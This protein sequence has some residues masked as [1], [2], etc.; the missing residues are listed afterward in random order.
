[1][2]TIQQEI[3]DCKGN[4]E[5]L[6]KLIASKYDSEITRENLKSDCPDLW[7]ELLR[8]NQ[9]DYDLS[10]INIEIHYNCILQCLNK[11]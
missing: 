5:A 10:Y 1:M 2:T 11:K 3:K 6:L 9:L 8:Y 4:K 7:F